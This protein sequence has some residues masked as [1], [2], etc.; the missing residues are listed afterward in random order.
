M[1][2]KVELVNGNTG[3]FRRRPSSSARPW[4]RIAKLEKANQALQNQIELVNNEL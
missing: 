1:C 2:E 3:Q 4:T